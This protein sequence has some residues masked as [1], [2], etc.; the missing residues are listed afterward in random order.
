MGTFRQFWQ[1][2]ARDIP[3]YLLTDVN[4]SNQWIFTERVRCIDSV[5]I[6]LEIANGQIS[7]I[8]ELTVRDT[9]VA[10]YYRFTFLFLLQWHSAW[11]QIL[12]F[13]CARSKDSN[14]L[15]HLHS[16][17]KVRMK[18]KKKK[19]KTKK[20]NFASLAVQNAP[21]WYSDQTVRMRRLIW[22]FTAHTCPMVLFFRWWGSYVFCVHLLKN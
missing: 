11:N 21:K 1:L 9:I 13:A 10:G 5:K 14:Q 7:S 2:S 6:C 15:S 20:K 19:K 18:K 22:I 3:E 12:V 17:S 4:L 16:L 8:F